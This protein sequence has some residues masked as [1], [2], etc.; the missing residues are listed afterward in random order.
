MGSLG[1]RLVKWKGLL[2]LGIW[3]III[4]AGA[5]LI[6]VGFLF[7]FQSQYIYFPERTLSADPSSIGLHFHTEADCSR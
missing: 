6:F 1:N 7:I 3:I 4:I 2:M 5:Y